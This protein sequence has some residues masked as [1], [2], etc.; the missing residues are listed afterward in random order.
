MSYIRAYL[1]IGILAKAG[2]T[3]MEAQ[4]GRRYIYIP[5]GSGTKVPMAVYEAEGLLFAQVHSA[6]PRLP[7]GVAQ[8]VVRVTSVDK[9]ILGDAQAIGLQVNDRRVSRDGR[10]ESRDLHESRT[11]MQGGDRFG[12]LTSSWGGAVMTPHNRARIDRK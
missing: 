9:M 2:L 6:F 11:I 12:S 4:G 1:N 8:G 5:T 10:C 7:K 3:M